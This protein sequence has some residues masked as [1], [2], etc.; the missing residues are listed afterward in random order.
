MSLHYASIQKQILDCLDSKTAKKLSLEDLIKL[1]ASIG[2]ALNKLLQE[3]SG[4]IN[5]LKLKMQTI[6]DRIRSINIT[7]PV[8]PIDELTAKATTKVKNLDNTATINRHIINY[9][10]HSCT[11]YDSELLYADEKGILNGY[12]QS[13]LK[14]K[15][16]DAITVSYPFLKASCEYQKSKHQTFMDQ[17]IHYKGE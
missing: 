14:N 7:I 16:L 6:E 9:L 2:E 15:I 4:Q 3:K 13:L 1:N 12:F 5:D 8:Y 10:R 11:Q 17:A